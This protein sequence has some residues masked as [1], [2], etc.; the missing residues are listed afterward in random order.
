MNRSRSDGSKINKPVRDNWDDD[1][2]EEGAESQTDASGLTVKNIVDESAA[3][4]DRQSCVTFR[5]LKE[6]DLKETQLQC[7][8]VCSGG[9]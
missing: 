5:N 6:F 7:K 8:V 1:D 3:N 2:E 9:N 4:Q